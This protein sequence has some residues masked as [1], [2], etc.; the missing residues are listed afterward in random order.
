M[1]NIYTNLFQIDSQFRNTNPTFSLS[2]LGS[3]QIFLI[4]IF[5]GFF[6]TSSSPTDKLIRTLFSLFRVYF[7]SWNYVLFIGGCG[8]AKGD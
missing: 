3:Y 7:C 5:L 4:Y 6:S 2:S 1:T 8:D